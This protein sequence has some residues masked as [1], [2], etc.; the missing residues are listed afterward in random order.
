VVVTTHLA[1]R[2]AAKPAFAEAKA[3]TGSVVA[4]PVPSGVGVLPPPRLDVPDPVD[5]VDPVDADT[6]GVE[7]AATPPPDVAEQADNS[8][9]ASRTEQATI[10][11]RRGT[12]GL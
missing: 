10:P 6:C 1:V 5:P 11:R 8:D 4:A 7:P 2:A 3:A 12:G 9:A